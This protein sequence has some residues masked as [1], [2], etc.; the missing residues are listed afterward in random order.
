[1]AVILTQNYNLFKENILDSLTDNV[2]ELLDVISTKTKYNN[3][4]EDERYNSNGKILFLLYKTFEEED[5][6]H[7]VCQRIASN[8]FI[9]TSDFWLKIIF[10]YDIPGFNINDMETI[11]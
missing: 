11:F 7:V 4:V 3:R 8:C 2:K 10:S 9:T 1:M 5:Y 6:N